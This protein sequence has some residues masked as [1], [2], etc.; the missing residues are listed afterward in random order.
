MQIY[1]NFIQNYK[2][3]PNKFKPLLKISKKYMH[4]FLKS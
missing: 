1:I 4:Y 3:M 2:Y